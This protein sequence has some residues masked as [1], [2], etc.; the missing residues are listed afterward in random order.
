MD[1]RRK[2]IKEVWYTLTFCVLF[3]PYLL[4]DLFTIATETTEW[5]RRGR[6]NE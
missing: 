2:V 4:I 3:I 5:E 6:Q 1:K